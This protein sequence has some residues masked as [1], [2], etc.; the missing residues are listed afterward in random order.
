[1]FIYRKSSMNKLLKSIKSVLL[2]AALLQ[3]AVCVAQAP[4]ALPWENAGPN[5][6]RTPF[7]ADPNPQLQAKRTAT[8]DNASR[9]VARTVLGFTAG[10][11]GTTDTSLYTYTGQRGGYFDGKQWVWQYDNIVD[12]MYDT[13][14]GTYKPSFRTW[15]TFDAN[16]NIT[17]VRLEWR[18]MTTGLWTNWHQRVYTFDGANDLTEYYEQTWNTTSGTWVNDQKTSYTYTPAH[19]VATA[20]QKLWQTATSSYEN[21][22]RAIYTYNGANDAVG[23]LDEVFWLS[24]GVWDT[25]QNIISTYDGAHNL[26]TQLF[27][28][29]NISTH[30]FMDHYREIYNYDGSGNVITWLREYWSGTAWSNGYKYTYTGFAGHQPLEEID[31]AWNISRSAFVNFYRVTTAYNSYNQPTFVYHE[32]W[33]TAAGTWGN[34]SVS[35]NDSRYYYETY[36]AAVKEISNQNSNYLTI[37]PLPA[38]NEMT[39]ALSWDEAQAFKIVITDMQGR[40]N[41]SWNVA[42]CRTHTEKIPVDHL[43]PGNYTITAT[44]A[45]GKMTRKFTVN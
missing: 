11:Y 3:P 2:A 20:T 32:E 15:Q 40:A 6:H 36:V 21:D 33:D 1:M 28:W 37:F 8:T 14:T 12:N 24:G 25:S 16:N 42:P 34:N 44:G 43:P 7:I 41:T 9:L 13:A 45:K 18:D 4:A 23:E 22:R 39:I 27:Q 17:S 5:S 35:M 10:V 31:Q 30:T 26:L 19:K 29:W 38:K